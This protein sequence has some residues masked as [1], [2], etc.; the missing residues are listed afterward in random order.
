MDAI[1]HLAQIETTK[2]LETQV[3]HMEERKPA[4]QYARFGK[5]AH[6]HAIHGSTGAP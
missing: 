4:M 5:L 6:I 3:R 1:L 2:P